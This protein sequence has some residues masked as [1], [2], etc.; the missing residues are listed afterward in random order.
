M[1]RGWVVPPLVVTRWVRLWVPWV[2]VMWWWWSSL[3]PTSVLSTIEKLVRQN[4]TSSVMIVLTELQTWPQSPKSARQV[5]NVSD[6][7][8]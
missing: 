1:F 3:I 7:R 8:F 4:Y 6:V 2:R 5:E